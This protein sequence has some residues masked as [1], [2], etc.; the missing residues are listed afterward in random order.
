MQRARRVTPRHAAV[1]ALA[2]VLGV[3]AM[4]ALSGGPHSPRGVDH[5]MTGLAQL[6]AD[7]G[8]PAMAGMLEVGAV[9]HAALGAVDAAA[10]LVVDAPA[11]AAAAVGAP[12]RPTDDGGAMAA[13]CAA[14]LLGLLLML[15]FG[16]I[17]RSGLLLARAQGRGTVHGRMPGSRAPPPRNLLAELC[18]LRT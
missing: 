15:G 2:V 17:G 10:S 4:H 9:A 13:M 14:V 6:P 16:L 7:G 5:A 12:L 18:V 8:T 1:T 11:D 3:L